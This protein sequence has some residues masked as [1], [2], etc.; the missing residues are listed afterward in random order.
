MSLAHV[1]YSIKGNYYFFLKRKKD[2][3]V[4][5]LTLSGHFPEFQIAEEGWNLSAGSIR[6]P[7]LLCFSICVKCEKGYSLNC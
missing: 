3:S 4:G 5:L 1:K 7:P 6:A 2:W